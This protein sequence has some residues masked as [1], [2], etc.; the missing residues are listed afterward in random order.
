[1]RFAAISGFI[2]AAVD[3]RAASP[4]VHPA[5]R[6]ERNGFLLQ[7]HPPNRREITAGDRTVRHDNAMPRQP[8]RAYAHREAHEPRAARI[9]DRFRDIA[10]AQYL[11]VWDLRYD[12]VNSLKKRICHISR[13]PPRRMLPP[14]HRPERRSAAERTFPDARLPG[15]R[16][17]IRR[18]SRPRRH[19]RYRR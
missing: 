5:V 17:G 16:S 6:Q 3:L 4:Y 7:Q 12:G 13:T 19:D 11:P 8:L 10:V 18:C 2:H 14:M 1:M 9:P 15:A